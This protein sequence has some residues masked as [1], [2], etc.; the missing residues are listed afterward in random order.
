MSAQS[1][2][3]V[4]PQRLPALASSHLNA[5]IAVAESG[6]FSEAALRL[7]LAQSS[8]SH[9]IKAV[10]RELGVQLFERGRHGAR[11]TPAGARVLEHAQQAAAALR[12]MKYPPEALSGSL[13]VVSCRSVIRQFLTPALSGF[14][15]LYPGIQVILQDTSGEHDEIEARVAA[16]QAD[17]GLGR[18]PMRPDLQT[19]A[20][21][22]DEY[23]VLSAA[24]Q[25][26]LESWEAFHQAAYI[27]CQEDCAPHVAAH[28]ARHS[29]CPA[30]ALLLKDPQVA[31]GMVAEGHGF[32]VLTSLVV[33][34]LPAGV[35]A[36]ALPTPLWRWIGSVVRP[37]VSLDVNLSPLLRAFQDEVLSPAALR[38]AAG[39]LA[40]S[41]RFAKPTD[42]G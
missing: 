27:V 42:A 11:L 3:S 18:L 41:L 8:V 35:R 23:L 29:R 6:S 21:F 22:A 24:H 38:G 7:N 40:P 5:L 34:P 12:A 36:Y 1:S 14:K 33:C 31:L 16:G 2:P 20:L 9:A 39:R 4:L 32:T 15:R 13:R 19:Q 17:L 30:P 25:P 37:D 28:I 10:E 26:R